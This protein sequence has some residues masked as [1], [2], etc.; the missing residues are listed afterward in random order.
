ME[1]SVR[2]GEWQGSQWASIDG[3]GRRAEMEMERRETVEP[4]RGGRA[5]Q[6]RAT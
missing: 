2:D 3:A 1:R 6:R 4:E 5:S